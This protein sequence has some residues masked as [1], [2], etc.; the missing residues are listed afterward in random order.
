M[1]L[2]NSNYIASSTSVPSLSWLK[3]FWG[4]NVLPWFKMFFWK[5]LR[6]S[7]PLASSFC[8][9]SM[10]VDPMCSFCHQDLEVSSHLFRD[11]PLLLNVWTWGTLRIFYPSASSESF[12]NWCHGFLS[13]LSHVPLGLFYHF[14]YM[15]WTILTLCNH[16]RFRDVVWDLGAFPTSA[17]RYSSSSFEVF[18]GSHSHF[19]RFFFV[20][21]CLSF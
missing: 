2:S 15:L 21:Y 12:S 14:F 10:P 17:V 18:F 7:L 5:L 9:W 16:A 13:N 11:C 8:Q 1:L 6:N 19:G 3:H 20:I 4:F